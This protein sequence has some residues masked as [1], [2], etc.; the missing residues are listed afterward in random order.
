MTLGQKLKDLRNSL[1]STDKKWTMEFVARSVGV[2][3][4]A[5]S[6]YEGDLSVPGNDVL[7]S[8]AKLYGVGVNELIDPDETPSTETYKKKKQRWNGDTVSPLLPYEKTK[9]YLA[10][11][12]DKEAE[13][14]IPFYDVEVTAGNLQLYFDDVE[15]TPE[16]YV[17][18]PQ[19]RGCI[20]CHVKGDSMYDRIY[21]GARLYVQQLPNKKYIDFGQIYLVVLDGYRLLKYIQP[22]P[23]DETKVRLVSHNQQYH[24]W[25]VERVDILN[26]FLVKGY[27]NQ[28]AM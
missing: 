25:D 26:L 20:M 11:L 27:E 28:N 19:Y 3:S 10:N 4:G 17:Y 18:A 9:L 6:Q 8:I 24:F 2:S 7:L 21:P 15:E 22:H 14:Y 5:I 12:P 16:G 1:K 13:L 23:T